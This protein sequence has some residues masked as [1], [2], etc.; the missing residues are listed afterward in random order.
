MTNA[1]LLEEQMVEKDSGEKINAHAIT[2]PGTSVSKVS[3]C[4]SVRVIAPVTL[5]GSQ[6]MSKEPP[7]VRTWACAGA[8]IESKCAACAV[9]RAASARM[10][11]ETI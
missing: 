6:V 3:P 2:G 4:M 8:V 5:P 1:P 9:T 10:A 7:G 11:D